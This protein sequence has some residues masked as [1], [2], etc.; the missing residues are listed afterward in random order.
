MRV[1]VSRDD[2]EII[3]RV[4]PVPSC[5]LFV[6]SK[7]AATMT[8]MTGPELESVLYAHFPEMERLYHVEQVAD[9]FL[10]L[11]LTCRPHH[12]RLGGTVSGP[13][14]MAVA[15]T[16]MYLALMAMIGPVASAVTTNLNINFLRKPA[17]VDVIA[18]ANLLKL[19]RR[20]AVGEVTM[21]SD[22]DPQP[23]AHATVTYAIPSERQ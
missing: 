21:Y 12:L 22:N 20:L 14:L 23:V 6:F 17:P 13:T 2:V 16:A 15:D 19:G 4:L 7:E 5:Y 3:C 1:V 18:K 11:R 9:H 8:K 10:Q